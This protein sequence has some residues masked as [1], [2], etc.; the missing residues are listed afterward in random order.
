MSEIAFLVIIA[1]IFIGPK[2]L[3]QLARTL[4]RFLNEMKRTTDS[5]KDEFTTKHLDPHLL[6]I[7]KNISENMD[8][9]IK[10]DNLNTNQVPISSD[11]GE[12]GPTYSDPAHR[13]DFSH[14]E[15][16]QLSLVEIQT[17]DGSDKKSE[18]DDQKKRRT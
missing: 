12:N 14:L 17:T 13:P 3:P 5:I 6:E 11:S 10:T 15:N 18:I 2:E 8:L 1:L 7:K 9:N 16:E 4:G